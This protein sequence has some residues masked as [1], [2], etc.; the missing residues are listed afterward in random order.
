MS[1]VKPLPAATVHPE[2]LHG[3]MPVVHAVHDDAGKSVGPD[4]SHWK[5]L[6]S[7]GTTRRLGYVL[8]SIIVAATF[9]VVINLTMKPR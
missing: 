5:R 9:L 2:T 8:A 3:V 1:K 4:A 7:H 6:H